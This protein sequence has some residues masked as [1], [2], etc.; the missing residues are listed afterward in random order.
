MWCLWKTIFK[1]PM[2]EIKDVLSWA[3]TL[4]IWLEQI[5][6]IFDTK[7]LYLTSIVIKTNNMLLL[8]LSAI[9]NGKKVKFEYFIV[10]VSTVWSSWNLIVKQLERVMLTKQ[11]PP[12]ILASIFIVHFHP[13]DPHFHSLGSFV[14][15]ALDVKSTF[16]GSNVCVSY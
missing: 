16:S 4:N 1:S 10:T 9:L 6:H 7:S 15:C 12:R 3:I 11:L 14:L 8:W 2:R 13:K 5:M